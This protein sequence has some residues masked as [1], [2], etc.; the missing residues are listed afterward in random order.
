MSGAQA[1]QDLPDIMMLT[2]DMALL[3]D[4]E[5]LKYV[6]LYSQDQAALDKA[7]SNGALQCYVPWYGVHTVLDGTS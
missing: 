4:P 7:F 3:E 1:T 2:T 5:Y 6:K